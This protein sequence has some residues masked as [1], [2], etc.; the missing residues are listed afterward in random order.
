MIARNVDVSAVRDV[1]VWPRQQLLYILLGEDSAEVG[2]SLLPRQALSSLRETNE[3]GRSL[4]ARN[5]ACRNQP[6]SLGHTV[7]V[8]R[9]VQWL[10]LR[11][12]AV[13]FFGGHGVDH[14][15]EHAFS[16]SSRV[17]SLPV[18]ICLQRV[19]RQTS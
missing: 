5:S 12:T 16:D 15:P 3:V 18:S 1:V 4:P 19:D 8:A 6:A 7:W 10:P 11:V 13:E 17:L 14:P 9:E 2:A